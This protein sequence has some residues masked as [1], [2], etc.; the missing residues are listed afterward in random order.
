LVSSDR[1]QIDLYTRQPGGRWLLTSASRSDESLD[2][3]SVG[4]R[5]TVA[6]LYENV[7]LSPKP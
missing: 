3:A 5:L 1:I 6:E 2:L 7:D 4:C